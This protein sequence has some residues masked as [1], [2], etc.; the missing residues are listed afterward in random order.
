VTTA[1]REHFGD[2]RVHELAAPFSASEDFGS[3]GAGWGVPSVFWY[4]AGTDPDA[5]RVAEQAGRVPTGHPDQPQP[6]VRARDSTDAASR[7]GS[8]GHRRARRSG[9]LR[10]G[11]VGV[12]RRACL[13]SQRDAFERKAPQVIPVDSTQISCEPRESLT[14]DRGQVD[15]D[16]L[17]LS[18]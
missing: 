3:F 16:V 9:R 5:Y 2:D 10:P 1:L 18:A 12:M 4:V 6:G 11:C 15:D 8:H 14:P 17:R 13:A 7:G